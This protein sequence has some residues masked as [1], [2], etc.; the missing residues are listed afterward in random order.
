MKFDYF[1]FPFLVLGLCTA[2]QSGQNNCSPTYIKFQTNLNEIITVSEVYECFGNYNK[3]KGIGYDKKCL[4]DDAASQKS[5]RLQ[6]KYP[7]DYISYIGSRDFI[8]KLN[9]ADYVLSD[10]YVT[11]VPHRYNTLEKLKNSD[12]LEIQKNSIKVQLVDRAYLED[13]VSNFSSANLSVE[14]RNR[15]RKL[16]LIA[17]N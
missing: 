8:V 2:A 4:T 17:C 6:K 9:G 11:G 7:Q 5:T 3:S 10:V 12:L 14:E 16:K 1:L 15:D 13:F